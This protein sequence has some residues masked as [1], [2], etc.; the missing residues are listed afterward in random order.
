[1]TEHSLNPSCPSTLLTLHAPSAPTQL[2]LSESSLQSGLAGPSTRDLDE[3]FQ[4][5]VLY[6]GEE[7]RVV[8]VSEEGDEV[9]WVWGARA[10]AGGWGTGLTGS[11]IQI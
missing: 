11:W 3:S 9:S 2:E 6:L 8:E 4:V 7:L 10:T 5:Q 1:M